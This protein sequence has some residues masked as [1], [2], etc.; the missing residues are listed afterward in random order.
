MKIAITGHTAGIGKSL[1]ARLESMGHE[2]VGI[3]KREGNN[4]R[5]I[6]KVLEQIL[7]CDVFI[8][9]AQAGYAQ[10]ELLIKVWHKW[11]G[12]ENKMIWNIST[13]M[14]RNASIPQ[15]PGAD[16]ESLLAYKNQKRALN[17][18]VHQLRSLSS[19]PKLCLISPG[20]VATQ[21]YNTADV[22][23]ADVDKWVD[24]LV[25]TFE[26]CRKRNLW[27]YEL[28]LEFSIKGPTL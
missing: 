27:P 23:S 12:D 18:A 28:S 17:D 8:N 11:R 1:A 26:L 16:P 9:N 22:N 2:I 13:T 24:A 25:D 3:S 21:P 20:S 5:N 4:I 19:Y 6:P 15:I 14:T 7:P 10:A